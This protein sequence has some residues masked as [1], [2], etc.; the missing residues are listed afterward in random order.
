VIAVTVTSV[1]ASVWPATLA[2]KL[3]PVEA[4]QS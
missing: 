2:A 3:E 4:L 1:V